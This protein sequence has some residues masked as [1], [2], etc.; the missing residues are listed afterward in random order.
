MD[1]NTENSKV[2]GEMDSSMVATQ[3]MVRLPEDL[4]VV[5]RP[6]YVSNTAEK[7]IREILRDEYGIEAAVGNFGEDKG[8]FIRLSYGVYNTE[9][10][11]QRLSDAILD[12]LHKQKMQRRK[13]K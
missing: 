3:A 1:W 5:D 9:E 7:P 10:D 8:S 12:L 13:K 11:I 6:G 4:K 2:S